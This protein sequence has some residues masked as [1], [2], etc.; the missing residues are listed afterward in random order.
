MPH[1]TY[2]SEGKD[3]VIQDITGD[4]TRHTQVP[5]IIEG[6]EL[7]NKLGIK[8]MLVD[9]THARNVEGVADS[10]GFAYSDLRNTPGI[11]H[12]FRVAIVTSPDDHSHDF[13]EVVLSNS[14]R[15]T[16]FFKDRNEA[17][18]YLK[19]EFPQST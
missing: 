17:I 16:K 1:R 8:K 10:F 4:I 19:L 14:G 12:G 9:M 7:G 11:S 2:V 3:I 5:V 6:H 18:A 13:I 15:D